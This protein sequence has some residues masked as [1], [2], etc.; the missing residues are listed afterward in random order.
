[1]SENP[2]RFEVSD[3]YGRTWMVEYRWQQTAISIRHSDTVDVKFQ[4]ICGEDVEEK[5]IAL[6]HPDLLS[7]STKSNRPLTDAW[8]MRLAGLHL[9][10]MIE[11]D[12]DMEKTLITASPDDLKRGNDYLERPL[13]VRT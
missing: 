12:R 10:Y 4:L 8:C 2:R 6:P 13:A 9:K 5:V 3:P 11:S 1:M 7:L